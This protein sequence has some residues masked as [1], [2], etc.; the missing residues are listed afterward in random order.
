LEKLVDSPVRGFAYEAAGTAPPDCLDRG[1]RIVEGAGER[2]RIP[3]AVIT[4]E[5]GSSDWAGRAAATV[6]GLLTG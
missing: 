1:R 3:V 5:R 2:W 6:A 4:T